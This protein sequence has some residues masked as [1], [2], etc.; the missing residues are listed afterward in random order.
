MPHM[1][2]I[3]TYI[4]FVLGRGGRGGGKMVLFFSWGREK[5]NIF[6]KQT[7]LSAKNMPRSCKHVKTFCRSLGAG[8]R[9]S[10]HRACT[11]HGRPGSKVAGHFRPKGCR[12]SPSESDA[13]LRI[14]AALRKYGQKSRSKGGKTLRSKRSLKKRSRLI[15]E[16]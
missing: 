14:A 13:A 12:A 5:K 10:P 15:E 16:I 11:K 2:S 3:G 8:R 4:F 6:C 9:A 1:T 7:H